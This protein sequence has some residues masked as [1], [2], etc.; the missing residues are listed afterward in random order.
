MKKTLLLASL[1]AIALSACGKK[2]ETAPPPADSTPPP[3]TTPAEPTP[4]PAEPA[5]PAPAE[6]A[7]PADQGVAPAPGQPQQ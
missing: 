3:M 6:P 1:L 5:T 7:A 4:A 2:E